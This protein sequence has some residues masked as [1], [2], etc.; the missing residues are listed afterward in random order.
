MKK[1]VL[2]LICGLFFLP[3][4]GQAQEDSKARM[5]TYIQQLRALADSLEAQL[6]SVK[7]S[8]EPAVQLGSYTNA[9]ETPNHEP[10]FFVD[11]IGRVFWQEKLPVY[12]RMSPNADG[13]GGT[14][15]NNVLKKEMEAYSNPMEWENHGVHHIKHEDANPRESVAFPVYADGLPPTTRIVLENA[16]RYTFRGRDFYGK[17]LTVTAI[18]EDQLSGVLG[19]YQ[20]INGA[21]YELY[22]GTF[23]LN[24][25]LLYTLR[26]YGTDRVGNAENPQSVE[27]TVDLEA[28]ITTLSLEGDRMKDILSPRATI[29]LTSG[30]SSSGVA[31]ILYSI[32]GAEWKNYTQ[33]IELKALTEGDYEISYYA[34]DQVR[35]QEA[36]QT[37]QFF[38]DKSA[39]QI[40]A[41]VKGDQHQNRGR[42]Y[43]S[44]RT[45]M[46]LKAQDNKSGLDRIY[47]S[48]DNGTERLYREPFPLVKSEGKHII[49]YAAID[50]VKN[51]GVGE[52]NDAY[53]NMFLDLSVP[54]L[55]HRFDG[56]QV[57]TRDTMFINQK[58]KIVLVSSDKDSGVKKTGY[59]LNDGRGETY[60]EPF[61]LEKNGYHKI[62]YYALD[63]VN[64]R[65]TDEFFIVGDNDG[66]EIQFSFSTNPVSSLQQGEKI[67]PAYPKGTT[68]FLAATDAQIGVE[69]IF[70]SLDGRPEQVYM[71]PLKLSEKG[72]KS[73]KVRATDELGNSTVTELV[74]I[75][76]Q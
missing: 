41:E 72:L 45:K 35:N 38:L 9:P 65:V 76:I 50:K 3:H 56:P 60:M 53:G 61:S 32:N 4:G 75:F 5:R 7:F 30:D 55:N 47:Y 10:T 59:K 2:L 42:V 20:S 23:E 22:K 64:N 21:S 43:I 63:N 68:I 1:Y 69:N 54:E 17:G 18:T 36:K 44:S 33:P 28:P 67:I 70:Y 14:M 19:T 8:A 11:S 73:L 58:T 13:S 52:T 48:I 57:F 62:D 37:Y 12:L 51:K 15:L 27:F 71:S 29:I 66:P 49:T 25:N 26:F 16:P 39:P 31:K 46:S 40:T 6:E 74:E 24:E 34:I